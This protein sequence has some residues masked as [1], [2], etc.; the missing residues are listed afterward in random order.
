M[1]NAHVRMLPSGEVHLEDITQDQVE[2]LTREIF[3]DIQ[4]RV[5]M[6]TGELSDSLKMY[7]SRGVITV[8]T[9]HWAPT[10]YGSAPHTIRSHGDYPLRNGETGQRFGRT[11][12]HPG[13]PEQPFIRPAVYKKRKLS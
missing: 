8:G 5:P 9:D 4:R 13:T 3:R 6:D 12:Q 11:V 1:A 10:E 2:H 7:P